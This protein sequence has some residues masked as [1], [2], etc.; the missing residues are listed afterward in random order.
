MDINAFLNSIFEKYKGSTT[1]NNQMIDDVRNQF[2]WLEPNKPLTD[3]E[4]RAIISYMKTRTD[5]KHL[6]THLNTIRRRTMKSAWVSRLFTRKRRR[7]I[8]TPTQ[9]GDVEPVITEGDKQHAQQLNLFL[10]TLTEFKQ[11]FE[12]TAFNN[13]NKERTTIAQKKNK[14]LRYLAKH[15]NSDELKTLLKRH[16]HR[17]LTSRL[18]QIF[19]KSSPDRNH[20]IDEIRRTDPAYRD[21]D[22]DKIS[23]YDLNEVLNMLKEKVLW[24]AIDQK[25]SSSK[26]PD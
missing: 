24:K 19:K 26:S 16:H 15:N 22:F 11:S 18:R 9:F 17:K 14:I 5:D 8:I 21:V 3:S 10:T 1:S 7:T 20:I 4:K 25:K 13:I 12:E 6:Y 2:P 23:T